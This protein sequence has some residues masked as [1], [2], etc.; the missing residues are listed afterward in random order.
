MLLASW[1]I[2]ENFKYKH[3]IFMVSEQI[4][5]WDNDIKSMK[6]ITKVKYGIQFLT[7]KVKEHKLIDTIKMEFKTTSSIEKGPRKTLTCPDIC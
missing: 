2:V 3:T 7:Y 4:A 1:E 6:Y 5:V